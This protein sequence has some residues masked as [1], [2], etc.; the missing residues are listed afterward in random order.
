MLLCA[1]CATKHSIAVAI[2]LL[3][4]LLVSSSCSTSQSPEFD[5]HAIFMKF[6]LA[7]RLYIV[8]IV[9]MAYI[10]YIVYFVYNVYTVLY[11]YYV[12]YI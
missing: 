1:I 11:I 8:Y 7:T 4:W 6:N 12:Y 10:V 2:F 3:D 9:Y 5:S